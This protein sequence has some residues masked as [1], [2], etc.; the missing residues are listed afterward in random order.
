[1]HNRAVLAEF[2]KLPGHAVIEAHAKCQQQIRAVLELHE[3]FCW[4]LALFVFAVDRPVRECRTVHAQPAQ[5]KR[6]RLWKSADA[7]QRG[8]HRNL[9]GLCELLQFIRRA[10]GDDA[11]SAVEDRAFGFLD[12]S[13]DFVQGDFIRAQI[14]LLISGQTGLHFCIR[15][16]A[17]LGFGLLKVLRQVDDDRA[18]ASGFRD[19]ERFL[20]DT[21][22]VIDVG[23]EIAVLY[24]GQGD[25]NDIGL[26]ESATTDHR[27]VHL[28]GDGDERAGIEIGIGDGGDEIGRAGA[29][30]AH[31]H[32]GPAGGA[33]VAFRRETAPLLMPGQ[34]GANLGFG[35]RL[36]DLHARAAGVGEDDFHAGAFEGFHEN[37]AP[38]HQRADF[39]F[40]GFGVF[41]SCRGR[42]CFAHTVF[43]L[44][45]GRSDKKTH[46]RFQPWVFVEICSYLRQAPTASLT[47][48][49][50]FTRSKVPI[51]GKRVGRDGVPGQAWTQAAV[52]R[53]QGRACRSCW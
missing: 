45:G 10:A 48:T 44:A 17:G 11:A 6:M 23:D 1:M 26:L 52:S 31:A 51:T 42:V 24:H 14:R 32:A 25:A 53:H 29:A 38:E 36:V 40:R 28:A 15:D 16:P 3:R 4:I 37:V 9:R 47:T 43:V 27:L 18:W 49:S 7:H 30:G 19:I 34:D 39:G 35:E 12:Q 13:D 2:F 8:G 5:R 22:N 20:H 41:L 21:R 46:D 33:S 50:R